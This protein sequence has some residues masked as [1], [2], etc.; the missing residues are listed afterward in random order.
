MYVLSE[1]RRI[2]SSTHAISGNSLFCL[3]SK[4]ENGKA[5]NSTLRNLKMMQKEWKRKVV[6]ADNEYEKKLSKET[7]RNTCKHE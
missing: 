4:N 6:E 7:P 1:F 5:E 2:N 3:H